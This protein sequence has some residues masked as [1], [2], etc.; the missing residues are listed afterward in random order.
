MH[1]EKYVNKFE[2]LEFGRFYHIYNRAVGSELLFKT[3]NDYFYFL[4]KFDRYLIELAEVYT[5]CLL[6]NHFHFLLR[7]KEEYEIVETQKFGGNEFLAD[8]I[9]QAFSNFFNSYTKSF[10]KIHKRKGKL[11]MLPYKRILVD[12]DDYFLI[13]I[14]YIHRNPIHHGLTN[15]FS[16][17]KYSSYNACISDKP[18]KIKRKEIISS[19]GGTD[20]FIKFHH[21]NKE[22]PGSGKYYLE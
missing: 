17:W 5:Y 12:E 18:T 2:M 3:E 10:N 21:E 1:S 16:N 19:F 9:N 22:K 20:K 13:L 4:N 15:N 14:N 11:F 7:I 6:P 8:K